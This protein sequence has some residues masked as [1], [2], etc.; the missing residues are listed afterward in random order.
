[1]FCGDM[2]ERGEVKVPDITTDTFAKMLRWVTSELQ[3]YLID[4]EILV[5]LNMLKQFDLYM[6]KLKSL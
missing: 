3:I 6:L 4:S 5:L 1:M 2:K